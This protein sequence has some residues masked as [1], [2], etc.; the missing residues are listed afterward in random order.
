MQLFH[1]LPA[2]QVQGESFLV[3][4]QNILTAG[5]PFPL[6]HLSSPAKKLNTSSP[7][8]LPQKTRNMFRKNDLITHPEVGTPLS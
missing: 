4:R 8:L 6:R 5:K 2:G 1:I 7:Y 3:T